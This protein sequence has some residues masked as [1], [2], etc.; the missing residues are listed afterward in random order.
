MCNLISAYKL[1]ISDYQGHSDKK[2][3]LSWQSMNQPKL[4][5]SIHAINNVKILPY[6]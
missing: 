5:L 3:Y 1:Q 6:K 2:C 4:N